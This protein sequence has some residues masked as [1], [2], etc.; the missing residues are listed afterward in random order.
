[1]YLTQQQKTEPYIFR[2][3]I[4]LNAKQQQGTNPAV[5][6]DDQ[7]ELFWH[8]WRDPRDRDKYHA[9]WYERTVR[10]AL[11]LAAGNTIVATLSTGDSTSLKRRD[12][13]YMNYE[14][15][16]QETPAGEAWP[17]GKIDPDAPHRV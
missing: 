3:M 9:L 13:E 7:L 17:V 15:V 4:S 12:I 11:P 10:L 14:I 16:S 2:E 5:C 8:K 1:M 6:Q